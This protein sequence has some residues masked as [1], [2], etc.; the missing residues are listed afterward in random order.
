MGF[1]F[2][3]LKYS[4]PSRRSLVYGRR[5]M[6]STSQPLAAQAGLDI[7]KKGGNAVDA[8]IATAICMTILEPTSNGIGGDCFALVWIKDKLYGLNGSGHAPELATV[9]YI[10]NQGYDKMPVHG[11]IPVTVPGQV[12]GWVELS[13]RF[14]KLKF[15]ELFE[16]AIEYAE[17]GYPVSPIISKLWQEAYENDFRDVNDSLFDEWKRVFSDNGKTPLAGEVWTLKDHAKTLKEIA[18]TKGESFYRGDLADKIDKYSRETGGLIRKSDL[19][20]FKAEW[21]E[22]IS[23][24]YKGYEIH[25]IPPNG[26]GIVALMALN[27]IEGLN[28]KTHDDIETIHRQIEAMKLAFV[29]GQKYV[30]DCRYMKV[31]KEELLSKEYAKK[32]SQLIGYNAIMPEYGDPSC[33]G[34]IYL[35]TADAEGNM[36]SYIQSNY[37]G[38][39]SGIVVPGTGIALHNR[40]NNFNL[41]ENSENCIAP[42]KKPYH[43]IIPGFLTK[44]KKAVGPFGVMGG[45]MQPQGHLQ[46]VMNTIDFG[47]NP[48]EALDA[49][50]WQWVGGKN[51]QV[52]RAFPFAVTE[53]LVRRGHNITVLPESTNMGRGQIIMR[54]ENGTLVGAS[55]PRT[56]G[57]VAA[58]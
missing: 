6:V 4:Y 28:V 50:R 38:F 20:K 49:P 19:A 30:S 18:K 11:W 56:D 42:N 43:T 15:E 34:T 29:D 17:N 46:V 53:E 37:C 57:F 12:S 5:G 26:H 8:A 52:E 10:K 23:I 32:R 41:D 40:G 2:D 7:I 31:T 33:G 36:V 51:I 16:P 13:N 21:V 27:I 39:G 3:A 47:M 22:P 44:N 14:G 54:D 24:N 55:E 45:F 48:Q 35:C 9:E 58:W 25:E 1:E